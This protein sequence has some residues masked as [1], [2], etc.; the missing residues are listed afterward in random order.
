M[1][2][3]LTHAHEYRRVHFHPAITVGRVRLNASYVRKLVDFVK[4]AATIALVIIIAYVAVSSFAKFVGAATL[5]AHYC[6]IC[7][8]LP[9]MLVAP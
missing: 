5:A 1:N 6:N 7:A 8:V 2:T 4:K 3:L 9:V